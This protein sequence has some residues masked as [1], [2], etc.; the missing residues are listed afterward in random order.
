MSENETA[1]A[2]EYDCNAHCRETEC[3]G[4]GWEWNGLKCFNQWGRPRA[5]PVPDDTA[6]LP[7]PRAL[8]P[9]MRPPDPVVYEPEPEPAPEPEHAPVAAQPAPVPAPVVLFDVHDLAAVAAFARRA[10]R[11]GKRMQW[12]VVE[13][14]RLNCPAP[15]GGAWRTCDVKHL[16][17]DNPRP[18]RPKRAKVVA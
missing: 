5:C 14:T 17:L 6:R 8:R 16:L 7:G 18:D 1:R 15:R 4:T 12:T 9:P 3:P 2:P 10:F 13:L 11:A